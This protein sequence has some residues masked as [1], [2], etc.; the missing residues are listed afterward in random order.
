MFTLVVAVVVVF[1]SYC[2]VLLHRAYTFWRSKGVPQKDFLQVLCDQDFGLL[3]KG[4]F[5]E[6]FHVSYSLNRK[7]KYIGGYQLSRRLV[8][9]RD[10]ELIKTIAIKDFDHFTDHRGF[11]IDENELLFSKSLFS[12]RGE[13]WRNM[14]HLLSPAFTTSKMKSMYVLMSECAKNFTDYV[15]EE[16]SSGNDV[17]DMRDSFR[18]YAT[19]V[20]ATC[21]YGVSVNSMKDKSN[22]FYL[23]GVESAGFG[24]NLV[25]KAITMRLFPRLA[26]L[27]NIRFFSREVEFFFRH[28]VEMTIA[29]RKEKG[30]VRP[31][32]IQLFIDSNEKKEDLSIE[33]MTS[34]AFIFFL[35]GFGTSAVLMCYLAHLLAIHPDVHE[36]LQREVDET[37]EET[38]GNPTYEA[39]NKMKY[40]EAVVSETMR[41]YPPMVFTDR[42]CTK[43]YVLPPALPGAEPIKIEPGFVLMIPVYSIQRDAAY[44]ENPEVFDPNRFLGDNKANVPTAYMPF[45]AGPRM[46]IGN[47]FVLL[48]A[49]TVIF[50][51]LSKCNFKRCDKTQDP[52]VF[53]DRT[54]EL[55]PTNGFWV[56]MELRK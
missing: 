23:R 50:Q 22:E 41:L 15:C 39:I 33:E 52:V 51:L 27:F 12:L 10:P 42:I 31:D 49:K 5:V 48:E 4:H 46:C 34:Q 38:S 47:R 3:F 14:R 13:K 24:K 53:D 35:G 8:V 17:F 43:D 1:T 55:L 16:T 11:E 56:K 29:A 45:G 54:I 30:I 32:L 40:M 28:I 36:K 25:F 6:K 18:R 26:S 19:D 2:F 9:L 20:I 7:A 37:M 21:A 44:F